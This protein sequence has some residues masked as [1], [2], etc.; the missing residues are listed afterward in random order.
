MA[1]LIPVLAVLAVLL[2]FA[3][4]LQGEWVWDDRYQL[5]GN[6]ALDEPLRSGPDGDAGGEVRK[7]DAAAC[8]F[9]AATR[10]HR[11]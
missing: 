8:F 11:P 1:R 9:A 2:A 4:S 7:S 5:A 3:P 6:A 10:P